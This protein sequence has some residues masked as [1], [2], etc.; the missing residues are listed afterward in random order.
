MGAVFCQWPVTAVLVV[1]WTYRLMQRRALKFWWKAAKTEEDFPSF[2]EGHASSA[3]HG[4]HPNWFLA[5]HARVNIA[6]RRATRKTFWGKLWC[7]PWGMT[8]SLY[9]NLRL[10]VAGM[11]N[12]WVVTLLPTLLW[13]FGWYSG[14]D[15]SFNKGYEQFSVG[16]SISLTGI[17]LFLA[18]MLY[19]PMAQA[20]QAVTGKWRSFYE[21]RK[22]RALIRR[23][24]A[25]C[26]VLAGCYSVASL[27]VAILIAIPSFITQINPA[28][29]D[30]TD[31][32]FLEFMNTYFFWACVVGFTTFVV[33]R[34]LAARLY[35]GAVLGAVRAG[36][37]PVTEL[38]EFEATA[39]QRLGLSEPEERAPRHIAIAVAQ[40]ASRPIVRAPLVV[41]TLAIWFTFVAQIY[42]GEFLNY[43]PVRGWMNQ[44]LVQLPWFRYV[45]GHLVESAKNAPEQ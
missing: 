7:L 34:L 31:L 15:N 14:W 24:R 33:L 43:H 45:P 4:I 9:E 38:S 23:R 17:V 36:E 18:V 13:V 1:G 3:G 29:N 40:K 16:V 5:Q 6:A 41:A 10:G 39:L 21:F 44:P 37:L 12:T 20:R 42:V 32:E 22:I 28:L 8:K 19:V 26:L 11:M 35:A 27:P 2:V 30:A 25:A